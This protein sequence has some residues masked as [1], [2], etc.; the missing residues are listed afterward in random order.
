MVGFNGEFNG[1]KWKMVLQNAVGFMVVQDMVMRWW[2][3]VIENGVKPCRQKAL[4]YAI[5]FPIQVWHVHLRNSR[6]LGIY[7]SGR[8]MSLADCNKQVSKVRSSQNKS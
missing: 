7:G 8:A 6:A 3:Y 2:V 5:V 4:T 1:A